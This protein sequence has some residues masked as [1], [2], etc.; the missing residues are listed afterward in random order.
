MRLSIDRIILHNFKGLA[1]ENLLFDNT[2]VAIFGANGAGKSTVACGWYWLMADCSETLVSN[3]AIFPLDAEEVIPSVEVVCNVDGKTI[4]LERQV[5]RTVKKSKADGVADAV[6]FSST[7]LV[8]SV[9]Y[10]LR[11]FKKKLEEY[12][13]TDRLLTLSH[14]DVFLSGK[15]DEMRKVL[16]GMA[17]G[18]TDLEVAR[19]TDGAADVAKLLESYTLEEVAA[20]QNANIRKIK[21]EY[22]R[23]GEILRAKIEG[24]AASKIDVDFAEIELLKN[25][26]NEKLEKNH[27]EQEIANQVEK[28]LNTLREKSMTLQFELSG[29]R[30]KAEMQRKEAESK[31]TSLDN[32]IRRWKNEAQIYEDTFIRS[33]AE[34]KKLETNL[35]N[36]KKTA[37]D[38]SS[39]VC[40]TC[41]QLYQLDKQE[42]LKANFEKTKAEQIA[43]IE[44]QISENASLLAIKRAE[45]AEID[46]KLEKA[47]NDKADAEKALNGV[48]N[49]S[50][51]DSK[52]IDKLQSDITALNILVDE[53][54]AGMPNLT[55]L[56]AEE[57]NLNGEI[58]DCEI[59]LS[60][61]D[62]NA[63]IDDMIAD[64]R[65]KQ[66]IYEQNKANAEKLLY[67]I[68]LI[69]KRKNELLTE[70]INSH[71]KLV[72]FKFF[73]WQKN[74]GYKEVCVPQYNG[75]DLGVAT[76]TGLEIRMKLDIIRGL[77]NFYGESYPVFVDG[78][79]ALDSNSL[80]QIEMDCQMI[81]LTVSEDK[82]LT[83]KEV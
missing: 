83:I 57:V 16:F 30:S 49:A 79:E 54:K 28:D 9:E 19:Q 11:D 32:D 17:K 42:E 23:D 13:I 68:D 6:S 74:G 69:S 62:D 40:P 24:L 50:E 53:K 5:R 52:E 72:K 59:K 38:D 8:N 51:T 60:K 7:Y 21:E 15:R 56:K 44:K 33:E 36:A 1:H 39:L 76:N 12:G 41:G 61:S 66:M 14:P 67:E 77:Q 81:Y 75:K 27:A 20:M 18:L 82:N 26:L 58:R 4:T 46:R 3:P 43:R 47:I 48:S 29:L 55:N 22:G 71:F 2:S 45:K 80:R 25:A 64:L 78:A 35:E 34:K 37:F 65:A 70:E 73:D 31:L 63:R 10:G